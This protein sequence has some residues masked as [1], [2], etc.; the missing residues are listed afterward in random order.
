M[1]TWGWQPNLWSVSAQFLW[2]HQYRLSWW[3]FSAISAF[4]VGIYQ[5]GL[6]GVL[7][8]LLKCEMMIVM[9]YELFWT[10]EI[11]TTNYIFL[12]TILLFVYLVCISW[13]SG[14][15]DRIAQTYWAISHS[16]HTWC[17]IDCGLY[18]PICGMACVKDLRKII[19]S[20]LTV[21]HILVECNHFAQERKDIF[22]R[23]DVSGIF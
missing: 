3:V 21:R 12:F 10:L 13:C 6:D 23:R 22:G 8:L 20:V 14:L 7:K 4:L 9:G 2:I 18:C 19:A 5:G 11:M 17:N 15:W 1:S 16:L